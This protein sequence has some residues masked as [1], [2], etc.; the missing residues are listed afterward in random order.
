MEGYSLGLVAP[1]E[2][3]EGAWFGHGGAW[4]TNC[5]VNWHTKQIRLWVIQSAG[6]PQPWSKDLNAAAEKF[7]SQTFGK[8][9]I[10]EYTGRTN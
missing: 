1:V 8:S 4:G 7:F 5:Y 3:T 10:D 6:G 9:S 2:D